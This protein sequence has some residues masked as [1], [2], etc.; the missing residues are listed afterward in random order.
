MYSKLSLIYKR[1]RLQNL[2][3]DILHEQQ[4]PDVG[5]WYEGACCLHRLGTTGDQPSVQQSTPHPPHL[6]Q[7]LGQVD[8]S[9]FPAL[10]CFQH[11]HYNLKSA[12]SPDRPENRWYQYFCKLSVCA[13]TSLQTVN[14]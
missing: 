6:L 8:A 7:E 1:I 10:H 5:R 2:G 13:L 12:E 9:M 11:L 3:A 4:F 14:I